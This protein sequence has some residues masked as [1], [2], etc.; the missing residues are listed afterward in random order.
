MYFSTK[1]AISTTYEVTK[2]QITSLDMII[3][4]NIIKTHKS[5]VIIIAPN[6]KAREE[7]NDLYHVSI[8]DFCYSRVHF[9]VGMKA[10][11]FKKKFQIL[12]LELKIYLDG[13][14]IITR[15]LTTKI[16]G[17]VLRMID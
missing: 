3:S 2:K 4:F 8:T 5:T 7:Q 13:F 17:N 14:L 15:Q 1:L 10:N 16:A 12:D 9:C 11:F 6:R